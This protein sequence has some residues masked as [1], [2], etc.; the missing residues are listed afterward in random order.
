MAQSVVIVD[1][2]FGS[3]PVDELTFQLAYQMG[4]NCE[5]HYSVPATLTEVLWIPEE[6]PDPNFNSVQIVECHNCCDCCGGLVMVVVALWDFDID[7]CFDYF[8]PF[9]EY[10]NRREMIEGIQAYNDTREGAYDDR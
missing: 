2:S 5:P 6:Y 10:T 3:S 7:R 9:G 1:D 4:L 8:L